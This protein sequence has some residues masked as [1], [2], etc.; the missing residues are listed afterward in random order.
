MRPVGR[1]VSPSRGPE[2]ADSLRWIGAG[3]VGLT[4]VS[5]VLGTL[6]RL[7]DSVLAADRIPVSGTVTALLPG[8]LAIGAL[9]FLAGHIPSRRLSTAAT[10]SLAEAVEPKPKDS[11]VAA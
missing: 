8:G 9:L 1:H 3:I 2:I 11:S 10:E 7:L 5:G 4:L 6:Y